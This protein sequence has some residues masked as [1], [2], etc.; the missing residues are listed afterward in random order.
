MIRTIKTDAKCGIAFDD[1]GLVTKL[2]Q[3][4]VHLNEHFHPLAN[5]WFGIAEIAMPRQVFESAFY[6][7]Q[8]LRMSIDIRLDD[9]RTGLARHLASD[10]DDDVIQ[11]AFVGYTALD[12]PRE[13]DGEVVCEVSA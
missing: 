4:L 7:G 12:K 3:S 10:R 2:Y 13:P 1:K 6:S 9:G 8:S 5:F 11:V